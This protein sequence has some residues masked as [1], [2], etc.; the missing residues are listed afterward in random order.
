M[1]YSMAYAAWSSPMV[2]SELQLTT[3]SYEPWHQKRYISLTGRNPHSLQNSISEVSLARCKYTLQIKS[4]VSGIRSRDLHNKCV[5]HWCTL[6][7]WRV[8][9]THGTNAS[10]WN[11]V[12]PYFAISL[13]KIIIYLNS[14][15]IPRSVC[16]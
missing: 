10:I 12:Y 3:A 11:A 4:I 15:Y 7:K 1:P 13:F 8:A 6:F 16:L 2:S 9:S 14:F 5:D